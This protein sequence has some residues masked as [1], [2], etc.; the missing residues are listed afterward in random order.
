MGVSRATAR[1][2]L[3]FSGNRLRFAR[4]LPAKTAPQRRQGSLSLPQKSDWQRSGGLLC[5]L[6]FSRTICR[7]L[8]FYFGFAYSSS[9]AALNLPAQFHKGLPQPR[10][11]SKFSSVMSSIYTKTSSKAIE[12]SVQLQINLRDNS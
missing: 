8:C 12:P 3:Y 9:S 4:R 7:N 6:F 2:G 11:S 10:L 5:A 1:A